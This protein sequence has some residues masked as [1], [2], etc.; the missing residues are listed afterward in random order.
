MVVRFCRSIY[1]YFKVEN[2]KIYCNAP[3]SNTD[4]VTWTLEEVIELDP[5]IPT[6][7]TATAITSKT[8]DLSW[9]A[10]ENAKSYNVYQDGEL[11]SNVQGTSFKVEGLIPST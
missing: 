1:Y 2:G 5:A 10:A 3:S 6:G 11:V 4:V 9:N 8:V 7:L